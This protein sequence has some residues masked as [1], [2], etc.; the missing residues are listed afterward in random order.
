M[1]ERLVV[2]QAP[3]SRPQPASLVVGPDRGQRAVRRR[4]T[5]SAQ[6]IQVNGTNFQVI[7]VTDSK[8]SNGATDQDDVAMAPLTAVQDTLTGYGDVSQIVV[9]AKSRDQLYAAQT[10]V[11][12]ILTPLAAPGARIDRGELQRHQP[13]LDPPGVEREQ[14]GVHDAAGRGGRDLAAGR[15]DRRDEHHARVGHRADPRDRHPQGG[16]RAALRT[17]SSSSSSRP[18]WCRCSAGSRA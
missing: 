10:E 2:H 15:R 6:T 5:R 16:R 3:R 18:C 17:S 11:T 12:N 4:Q 1:A 7:G 13:G 8:G 14:Q 9:Q